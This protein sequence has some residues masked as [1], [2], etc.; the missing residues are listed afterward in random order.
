MRQRW[1]QLLVLVLLASVLVAPVVLAGNGK[2]SGVVKGADGTP[3]VGANVVLEGTTLGASADVNGRFF[4]LNIPPGSYRVRAS[5]VGFTPKVVTD[6]RVGSDQII[7]V[8]FNLQSEAVGLAEVVVQAERPPVD[9]SQTS[10]RTRL[11]GDDF[12]TLPASSVGDL[13]ATSASTYKGFVRGGRV[14]ETKTLID[15]IDV[16]DQYAAWYSD[17]PGG[18]T[19][20][21][22]YNGIVRQNEGNWSRSARPAS[23]KRTSL[24]AASA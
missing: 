7:T 16:T 23:R 6:V 1:Y 19:P 4:I 10:A 21:L 9:K 24:P 22:T 20:Y 2:I 11:S 14:F 8:D 15:G 18:N 17:V 3:A 12:T 5:A 13:V